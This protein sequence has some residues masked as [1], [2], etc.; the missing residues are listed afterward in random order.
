[1]GLLARMVNAMVASSSSVR[2]TGMW[3]RG[4]RAHV[5]AWDWMEHE[6][7][8]IE[9]GFLSAQQKS[10]YDWKIQ[11]KIVDVWTVGSSEELVGKTPDVAE[12][13]GGSMPDGAQL[14]RKLWKIF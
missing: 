4:I 7:T 10:V 5:A 3:Q 2:G 11:K 12:E 8:G 1:M 6:G 9:E 14:E 13:L